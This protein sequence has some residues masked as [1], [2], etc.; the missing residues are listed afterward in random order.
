[1]LDIHYIVRCQ[2]CGK[3]LDVLVFPAE[4][5][6]HIEVVQMTLD[7]LKWQTIIFGNPYLNEHYC[8]EC[9]E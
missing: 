3:E 9:K 8:P 1:M 6:K 7:T 4:R 5:E 2:D